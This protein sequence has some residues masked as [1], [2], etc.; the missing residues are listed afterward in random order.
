MRF[1]RTGWLTA[2][3]FSVLCLSIASCSRQ[4]ESKSP[5]N[6]AN[7]SSK[8]SKSAVAP[9][10]SIKVLYYAGLPLGKLMREKLPRFEQE[11]GISVDMEELQYDAVRAKQVSSFRLKRGAFD[12][13]FV[14]DIWLHEYA[15]A[16]YLEPLDD[17]LK[18]DGLNLDDFFETVIRAEAV[19]SGTT[20]LI[21]QRADVQVLFYRRDLFE[22]PTIGASFVREVG[23]PLRVP[24]T[25]QEYR[26][27]SRF[28]TKSV[29]G[30]N[31]FGNAETLKRPHFAFEFFAM[32]YW[33]FSGKDFFDASGTP[34][35]DGP[36]GVEAL[37]FLRSL[38]ESAVPGSANAAHDETVSAFSSAACAMAPQWYAFYP[39]LT[40]PT[41]EVRDKL[42]V[43]LVPG[44]RQPNG[45][46]RRA[47][48]IGG[49]SL[50][51]PVDSR[52]KA[53]AW[54]FVKFMTS[55]EFMADA[56]LRGAIV[57]RK[58]AYDDPQVVARHP[59][60]PLYLESLR[61][62]KFR[63][64]TAK[65]TEVEEVIGTAVSSAYTGQ[66]DPEKAIADAVAELSRR[67]LP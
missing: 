39:T 45:Q 22:D 17:Y 47:P 28:F 26:E 20:W 35:F 18:R 12:V 52:N 44:I 10:P 30:P 59:A 41:S 3:L 19:L 21:P 6:N 5:P 27:V 15:T 14:D 60:V 49:G 55:R 33:A 25:W 8:S 9:P 46:I 2:M 42:G 56:A 67:R 40:A 31:L 63:P 65:F 24:E 64:R 58:S 61:T 50:G 62:A 4:P 48:S 66:K 43:A 32:R 11:T 53:A 37:A 57:P 16:G 54:T 38:A 29:G 7:T 51:I 34:Q 13:V 36:E 1:N 23:K